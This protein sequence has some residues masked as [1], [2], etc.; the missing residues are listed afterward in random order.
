MRVTAKPTGAYRVA[1]TVRTDLPDGALLSIGLTAAGQKPADL[2]IG[3]LGGRASVQNGAARFD[4]DARGAHYPASWPLPAGRY[5]VE[6]TF[7]PDWEENRAKAAGFTTV[8]ARAPVTLQGSGRP[9]AAVRAIYERQ[10]ALQNDLV[11]GTPWDRSTFDREHGKPTLLPSPQGP[12]RLDA[13]YYP[14]VDLTVT[15]DT[16]DNT[17]VLA[18]AGRHVS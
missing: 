18:L 13:L 8:T 1:V 12:P 6:A 10:Y 16:S 17:V 14:K 9:M 5:N 3:T 11:P 2:H 4:L 7:Y 15:V